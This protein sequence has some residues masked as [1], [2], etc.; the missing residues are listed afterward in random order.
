MTNVKK[1]IFILS[2]IIIA[3]EINTY[4]ANY[5][6]C[7]REMQIFGGLHSSHTRGGQK[8]LMI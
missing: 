5:W 4:I 1:D 3:Y 2:D 6:F 8:L 7:M